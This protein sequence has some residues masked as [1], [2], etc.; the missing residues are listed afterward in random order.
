M[1]AAIYWINIEKITTPGRLAILSRPSSLWLKEDIQDWQKAGINTVVSVLT[2]SEIYE[3]ELTQESSTCQQYDL[4]YLSFPIPD[5]GC[6]T[7]DNTTIQMIH[8]L[9][10]TIK[11]GSNLG[12]HC[13]AGIGRSALMI[14]AI[15]SLFSKET[16]Y[17][18]QCISKARGCRVPDTEEQKEWLIQFQHY[19]LETTS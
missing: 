8:L 15:L 1:K 4:N 3:L 9:Q 12:I 19:I 6:P 13:R 2:T 5:R 18:W 14:A 16:E 7:L 10:N 11:K 17:I